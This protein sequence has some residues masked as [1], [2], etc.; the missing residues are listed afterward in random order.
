MKRRLTTTALLVGF[1]FVAGCGSIPSPSDIKRALAM[2]PDTKAVN[3]QTESIAKCQKRVLSLV[4]GVV[5]WIDYQDAV[6]R[7]SAEIFKQ[8]SLACDSLPVPEPEIHVP[9]P[10]GVAPAVIRTEAPE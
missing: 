9:P 6:C 5:T 1:V 7:C 10:I 3:T 8:R 4:T 2:G